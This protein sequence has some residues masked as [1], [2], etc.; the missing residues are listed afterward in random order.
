MIRLQTPDE[1]EAVTFLLSELIELPPALRFL[2]FELLGSSLLNWA[3]AAAVL[4]VAHP[5][6]RLLISLLAGRLEKMALRTPGRLDELAASLLRETKGLMVFVLALWI[7][8]LTL[9]PAWAGR[10]WML[11]Q[12]AILIQGALWASR[13]VTWVLERYRLRQVEED[14][15]VAT[16][17]G[18]MGFLGRVAVWTIV[19]LTALAALGFEIG[20]ALAGLGVGG[21]AIALAVQN[22]LG[23]LFASLSIIFD[24]P[25]VIGDFIIVGEQLGTV[26]HVGLKTTRVRAL[27]G[28]QLI[29][30]NSDLLNSRVRNFKR[31]DERRIVFRFGVQYDTGYERLRRIPGIVDEIVRGVE[32]T[33]F[34]RAHFAEFAD[35]ALEF[36]VVYHML[37]PDFNSYMDAQQEI[38][39]EL[40]RR[41][42]EM[43]VGFAFP[44]RTVHLH[45][46]KLE[47]PAGSDASDAPEG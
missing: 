47:V 2:E 33:R 46:E 14:P 19:L 27:S 43:E 37:V 11:V 25:F 24:R 23:D 30:S 13:G 36:E 32:N 34:D 6:L 10:M 15:G 31:M 22:I 8:S 26:E 1:E 16:A 21:I 3:V 42:E 7:A 39:L 29:F 5:L 12:V 40:Y 38:N 28:E 20:P 41:L 18:A 35:S 44:T 9:S 4:T 45:V 17:V